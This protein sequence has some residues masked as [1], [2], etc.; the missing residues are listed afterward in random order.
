[1]MHEFE[2]II[3]A[4]QENKQQD[5]PCVLATVV[6]LEGTS[7]RKPGVRMLINV[8]GKMVGAVSGGCVEKEIYRQ[9]ESVFKDGIPKIITYDGRFRL[10]CEGILY[11]L[12]EPMELPQ[13]FITAFRNSLDHRESLQL[14]SYFTKQDQ[15]LDRRFGTLITCSNHTSYAINDQLNTSALQDT[16]SLDIFKQ[17]LP[18]ALRLII[19]GAEHD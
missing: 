8:D 6:A 1:M 14:H 12:I 3:T 11:I 4:Y 13:A 16:E 9:S 15:Q 18:A 2:N 7:Y 17:K 19:I 5:K 10:G